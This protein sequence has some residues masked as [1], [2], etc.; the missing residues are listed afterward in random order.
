MSKGKHGERS[1]DNLG[2]KIYLE[3]VLNM[4]FSNGVF[5]FKMETSIPPLN[6]D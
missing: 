1:N 2:L 6:E 5:H 3:L 4:N